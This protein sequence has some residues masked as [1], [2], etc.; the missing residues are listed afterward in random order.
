[1]GTVPE[2]PERPA[3][4]ACGG[5]V[6][7]RSW[8]AQ[9][10]DVTARSWRETGKLLLAGAVLPALPTAGIIASVAVSAQIWADRDNTRLLWAVPLIFAGLLL[11]L[12]IAGGNIVARS[13]AGVA[14]LVAAQAGGQPANWRA[15]F[16]A[17]RAASR[18]IWAAYLAGVGCL[19]VIVTV[20]ANVMTDDTLVRTIATSVG[21]AGLLGP[22]ILLAPANGGEAA[23]PARRR[24][25]RTGRLLLL[26]VAVLAVQLVIGAALSPLVNTARLPGVA[27][28]ITALLLAIPSAL[29]LAAAGQASY[30]PDQARGRD[31]TL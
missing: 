1:V 2:Q 12:V 4:R 7:G 11:P 15:G 25:R 23:G 3:Y 13:W 28:V 18:R 27:G 29:V 14:W 21:P 30:P 24:A 20:A 16:E 10:A 5:R 6:A 8:W 26:V 22:L 31:S 19:L 9:V 17:D